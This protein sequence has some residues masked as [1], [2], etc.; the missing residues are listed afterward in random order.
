V[1]IA[2]LFPTAIRG[3]A[4]S[5]AT[6][7]LWASCLAVAL[8][9]LTL[10]RLLSPAGIFW[11]YALLSAVTFVF[12][13]RFVPETKGRSLEQIQRMWRSEGDARN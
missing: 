10:M 4:M 5:V 9:F 6:L 2:E 7:S 13:W 8:S 1:Y 3:R 11:L 12:V